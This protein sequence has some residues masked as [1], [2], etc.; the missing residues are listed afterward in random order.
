VSEWRPKR[1][2]TDTAVAPADGGFQVLLDGK[3]LRTP[4]KS[5]L[6]VPTLGLARLL[7]D[8]WEAQTG[9]IDP[10][11]MPATRMANSAID[12]VARQHAAVADMVAEYARTDLLCYRA[13]GPDALVERQMLRWNP[14]LDWCAT[15]FGAPLD[16]ATG[17]MFIEQP[18][19]S[20][21]KLRKRVHALSHWQLA[22][23][24]DLVS[25]S[26][27]L[28]MGLAAAHHQAPIDELWAV[29]RL[30]E[31]WQEEHWGRDE[32]ATEL[33][34]SRRGAFL[35]ASR[36]YDLASAGEA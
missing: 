4:A 32:I 10:L 18:S 27:S 31:L 8:E 1:F 13:P 11:T 7:A 24:H 30:D 14:L 23:F 28:V 5:S 2:W 19:D 3:P 26:G 29:S 9:V 15:R 22:A 21:G 17:V 33:S 35:D 6:V 20:I 25:L 36:F 16:T 34:E 12:K